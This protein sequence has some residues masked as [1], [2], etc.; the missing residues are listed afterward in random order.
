MVITSVEKQ[1]QLRK[2]H[3]ETILNKEAPIEVKYIPERDEYLLANMDPPTANEVKSAIDN[4]KSGKASEAD[5]VSADMLKVGGDVITETLKDIIKEIWEEKEIP[6]DWKTG[7]IVKLPKKGNLSLCKKWR[8]IALMS[9][10][11][12]YSAE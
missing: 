8:V 7:I 9:I 3:F 5:D 11:S 10:T 6:V 4:M 12:K 2:T 1:T